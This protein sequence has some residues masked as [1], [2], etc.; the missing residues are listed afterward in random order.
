MWKMTH[1]SAARQCNKAGLRTGNVVFDAMP[2]CSRS[3]VTVQEGV[4]QLRRLAVHSAVKPST[5]FG[6]ALLAAHRRTLVDVV[7]EWADSD[8][9]V[10]DKKVQYSVDA[11][12]LPLLTFGCKS[13]VQQYLMKGSLSNCKEFCL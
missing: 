9:P 6:L 3:H 2:S 13:F 11:L 7:F 8:P 10:S 12:R 5:D 1:T 4:S